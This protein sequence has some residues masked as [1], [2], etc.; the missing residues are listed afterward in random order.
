[1]PSFPNVPFIDF[2]TVAMSAVAEHDV[3]EKRCVMLIQKHDV[4]VF[5]N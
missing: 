5:A 4:D 3:F 2:Q 1:M